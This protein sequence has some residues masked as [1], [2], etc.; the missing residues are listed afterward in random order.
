MELSEE[1][2]TA[3]PPQDRTDVETVRAAAEM[4]PCV[5]RCKRG[6]EEVG[7]VQG[8]R[9]AG[10]ALQRRTGGYKRFFLTRKGW[11]SGAE[12]Q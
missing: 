2:Y 6:S 12:V 8:R 7:W 3:R 1:L 9:S 4:C 10:G 11:C 5:D